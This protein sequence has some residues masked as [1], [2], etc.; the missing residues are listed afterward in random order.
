MSDIRGRECPGVDGRD[1]V[2]SLRRGGEGR[3]RGRGREGEIALPTCSTG[4]MLPQRPCGP[5][6]EEGARETPV[7]GV[8]GRVHVPAD[9][10][11]KQAAAVDSGLVM[12]TLGLQ[13]LE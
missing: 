2:R 13:L 1:G 6:V 7:R 5:C 9:D 11:S 3:G 8:Q 12:R 4:L 10:K